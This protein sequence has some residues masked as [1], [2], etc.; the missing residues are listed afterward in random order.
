MPA[1]DVAAFEVGYV[2]EDGVEVRAPLHESWAVAFEVGLPVRRFTPRKGQRHL[3][4]SWWSATT[5]GHIGYESWLERDHL[6]LLDHDRSVVG[7]ASQ[8]MWLRWINES[9]R[10]VAHAPDY[11]VRRADGNGELIDCRPVERRRPEDVAR[12]DATA[13]ACAQLGWR[14]RLVDA[15]DP[16]LTANL[17]WLAGYRHPR[18]RVTATA[19]ALL[20]VCATPTPLIVAAESVGDPISVLPVLFHLV[21][22]QELS[23]DL[24]V[25]LQGHRLV[26]AADGGRR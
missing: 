25:P 24:S 1:P 22:T 23:A 17:R 4:G 15:V 14:Y 19:A 20:D 3:S 11:F 26:T 18:Y 13:Q 6:T 12:F 8:P 21:W 7:I 5:G 2:R 10:S 16:L 9:G